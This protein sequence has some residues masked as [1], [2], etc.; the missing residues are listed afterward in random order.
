MTPWTVALM[1]RESVLWGNEF[2]DAPVTV[3][4]LHNLFNAHARLHESAPDVVGL[5]WVLDTMTRLAFE[6]FGFQESPFKEVSRPHVLMVEGASEVDTE[7]LDDAAWIELFGAPFGQVVGATFFLH[8]AAH[9]GN[10]Y[11]DPAILDQADLQRIFDL[12]PREVILHRADQLTA[13]FEEFRAAYASVPHPPRGYERFA[14]NP[15]VRRPFLR[16][17]DGRLLAPQ[18]RLILPTISP[19]SL[20]YTAIEEFDEPFARDMGRLTEHYVGKLLRLVADSSND[21]EIHPEIVYREG[22]QRKKSIDWFLVLPGVVVMFEVKSAR[23]GLLQRAAFGDYREKVAALLNNANKQITRTA[24]LLDG[25]HP[26]FEHIPADRPRIGVVVTCEP[27]Y[28]S[29]TEWAREMLNEAPMPT[30][31]ASLSEVEDLVVLSAEE[32]ES[33]LLAIVNDP[34]RSTWSLGNALDHKDNKANPILQAAWDAYPW[35]RREDE[36]QSGVIDGSDV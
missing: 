9:S 36:A 13:S 35:P 14:Y 1:A 4:A 6:Q 25:G 29:N 5:E 30:L 26:A 8:M 27:H 20:Y 10:G 31:T 19:N 34:D 16:M 2:R 7:V 3:D 21:T 22:K 11:F 24:T 18:P 12:W 17:P 28:L 23:F 32:I 15:L 33:Q